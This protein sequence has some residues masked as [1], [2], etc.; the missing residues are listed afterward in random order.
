MAR[1]RCVVT[2]S[3]SWLVPPFCEAPMP[4]G[5]ELFPVFRGERRVFVLPVFFEA[6][7]I[8]GQGGL[9]GAEISQGKPFVNTPDA[10]ER[11]RS[12]PE[13]GEGSGTAG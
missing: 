6:R 13:P 2:D 1:G 3:D 10:P 4:G 11:R 12:R 7:E 9:D 5:G 8:L